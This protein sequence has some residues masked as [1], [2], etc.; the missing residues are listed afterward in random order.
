MQITLFLLLGFISIWK[1]Y[2]AAETAAKSCDALLWVF[3]DIYVF[4]F[5]AQRLKIYPLKQTDRVE[6][7]VICAF[8]CSST[9]SQC[10]NHMH[11]AIGSLHL[12]CCGLFFSFT[13]S[14]SFENSVPKSNFEKIM[15]ECIRNGRIQ[16]PACNIPVAVTKQGCDVTWRPYFILQ[17]PYRT[18]TDATCVFIHL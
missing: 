15:E 18:L 13:F 2:C 9:G 11:S 8:S 16:F 17:W 6:R 14:F 4:L 1:D 12:M 3:F 5:K 10:E 7:L